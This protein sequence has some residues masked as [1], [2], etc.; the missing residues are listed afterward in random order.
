MALALELQADAV[1]HEPFAIE[2]FGEAKRSKQAHRAV[3]ENA[4]AEPSLHIGT[5]ASLEY[6]RLDAV[7]VEDVRER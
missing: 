2:S 1:V 7:T 3:L 5:V 6:G 4:C